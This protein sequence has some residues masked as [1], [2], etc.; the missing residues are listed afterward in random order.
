MKF[1]SQFK[2]RACNTHIVFLLSALH[3]TCH[4]DSSL[5]KKR[6]INSLYENYKSDKKKPCS[7]NQRKIIA[8]YYFYKNLTYSFSC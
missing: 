3:C 1:L 8:N 2:Y 7:L 4:S 6:Q 5:V